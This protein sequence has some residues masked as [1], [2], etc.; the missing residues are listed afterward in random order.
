MIDHVT[1]R[2]IGSNIEWL[3]DKTVQ[4]VL[5]CLS[6]NDEEARIVGGAVRNH[7]LGHPIKDIDIA[8]TCKPDEI[9]KRVVQA[10]FKA[11][12]TGYAFGTITVVGSNQAFEVTTLRLDVETDG[13]HAKVIFGRD[14]LI[15]AKRR[16]FTMNALYVDAHGT[17]YDSVGGIIDI[18]K[19]LLRFIGDPDERIKEDYLRILRFF[20]FFAWYGQ[21]R[22]DAEGLKACSRL[23]EG[24]ASLSSER[25]WM[26]LKNLL[27][28]PDPS[29]ALLWMRQTGVLTVVL[30]ET[31]KWGIDSI[32]AL[33]ET[34]AVNGWKDDPLLRLE[35]MV[36][37]DPDRLKMMAKRMR[38][39]NAEKARLIQWSHCLPMK[40]DCSDIALK[41][42]IYR[43]GRQ[44]VMDRLALSLSAARAR[45]VNDDQAL[46]EAGHYA[47]LYAI[48][49]SFECPLFP[50]NGEDLI[51][52]GYEKGPLLG[53]A[54][55]RLEN[56]WLES[57]FSLSKEKL[58]NTLSLT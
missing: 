58:I 21:G 56:I 7:L 52:L 10:G 1:T 5:Y 2:N 19:R 46:L 45:A 11:I 13:R 28:A 48:A 33:V 51:A 18:E 54:L 37:P 23:K 40:A 50:V 35:A 42:I 20:R 47:R 4:K 38:F 29:R 6:K 15:D 14:W 12:S 44:S 57:G 30:P 49:E 3:N 17:L 36:P 26:E 31:D 8:T 39:S 53:D 9:I 25:I 32:H 27:Q 24:L 55:K 16:D 41:K 34:G 43:Y 22:P